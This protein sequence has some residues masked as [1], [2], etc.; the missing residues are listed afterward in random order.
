[1]TL[2][3]AFC[4]DCRRWSYEQTEDAARERVRLARAKREQDTK[5]EIF[6]GPRKRR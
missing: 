6:T 3:D 4:K 2:G 5:T 1:M